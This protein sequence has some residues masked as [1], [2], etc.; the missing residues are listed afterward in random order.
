MEKMTKENAKKY[1]ELMGLDEDKVASIVLEIEKD[2]KEL[3]EADAYTGSVS[4]VSH[5]TI[6]ALKYKGEVSHIVTQGQNDRGM[7]N[8][9]EVDRYLSVPRYE[10]KV[11][12]EW[13]GE[14]LV[15]NS[16]YLTGDDYDEMMSNYEKYTLGERELRGI[17]IKDKEGALEHWNR[18]LEIINIAKEA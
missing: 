10:P 16:D 14:K 2:L 12:K 9:G 5:N 7:I 3:R 6:L 4:L 1:V 11:A 8:L 15:L 13:L 18:H 17:V